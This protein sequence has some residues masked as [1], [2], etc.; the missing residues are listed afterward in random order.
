[1]NHRHPHL[2][3][4]EADCNEIHKYLY[5]FLDEEMEVEN[6]LRIRE[7]IKKCIGC[8]ELAEFEEKLLNVIREK[9]R[10]GKCPESLKKQLFNMLDK[11]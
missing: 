7:H 2:P 10:R 11:I 5:E 4:V 1:M 8:K 3:K 6:L 9:G